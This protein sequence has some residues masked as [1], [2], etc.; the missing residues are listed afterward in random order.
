MATQ[1]TLEALAQHHPD[2]LHVHADIKH[3]MPEEDAQLLL[4]NGFFDVS[5]GND[6]CPSFAIH[7]Y[8][9]CD[10]ISIMAIDDID[11]ET[12]ERRSDTIYYCVTGKWGYDSPIKTD[13]QAV[14]E[15]YMH[16]VRKLEREATQ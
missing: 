9:K 5:Y 2:C 6:E 4:N 1:Q 7:Q 16:L 8:I 11:Y 12:Y 10:P 14:I 13:L 15:D 3:L